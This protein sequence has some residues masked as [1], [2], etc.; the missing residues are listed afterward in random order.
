MSERRRAQRMRASGLAARVRPGHT[1][2]I[3][4][5]ST[6]GA[7]LEAGRPLRPG[8]DVEGQFERDDRGVRVTARV[9]RCAIAAIHPERGPTYRAAVAFNE[10]LDWVR[11]VTTHDG[12]AV[13]GES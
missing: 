1:V 5:V 2:R 3:V 8:A 4:N 11:E 10:T 13:P 9:G 6:A 12:H 7:L